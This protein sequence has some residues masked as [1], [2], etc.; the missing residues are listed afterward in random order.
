MLATGAFISCLLVIPVLILQIQ[1]KNAALVVVLASS[2]L[3]NLLHMINA[4][5]WPSATASDLWHGQV[6]CDVEVKLY[7]GL[8]MTITGGIVCL[9]RQLSIILHPKVY[10]IQPVQARSK[11]TI[12]FNAMFL[13]ILP[14]LRMLL[15]YM[16]QPDRYG[17]MGI[18]GCTATIDTS[19]PS[20]ALVLPWPLVVNL[21]GFVYGAVATWRMHKHYHD[22]QM[23]F[24]ESQAPSRRTALKR[25]Y[26][27]GAASFFVDTPARIYFSINNWPQDLE[28]YSWSRIHPSDWAEK[29]RLLDIDA[30]FITTQAASIVWGILALIILGTGPEGKAMYKLWLGKLLQWSR[31]NN[32]R[33]ERNDAQTFENTVGRQQAGDFSYMLDGSDVEVSEKAGTQDH[34]S[35]P[36]Q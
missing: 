36:R 24:Y 33:S 15:A 32:R 13:G 29:I 27:F 10:D 18:Y 8:D 11:M 25:M 14:I 1:A 19:W 30:Y 21:I 3:Y 5:I 34:G 6:L 9:F 23:L 31:I 28:L 2:L 22:M 12:I 7:F 26:I 17:V 20:Y 16:V 35:M 4:L